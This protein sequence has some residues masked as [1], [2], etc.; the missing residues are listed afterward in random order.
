[1]A[2]WQKSDSGEQAFMIVVACDLQMN[3]GQ[4]FEI[5]SV[6]GL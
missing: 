3:R 2:K 4:Y 5:M 1:M 6:T